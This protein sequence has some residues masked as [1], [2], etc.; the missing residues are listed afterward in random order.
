ML[1]A[2]VR[3]FDEIE[4][5]TELAR[6]VAAAADVEAAPTPIVD[7]P[8]AGTPRLP[9]VAKLDEE[10]SM[11]TESTLTED[12]DDASDMADEGALLLPA[13]LVCVILL[14]FIFLK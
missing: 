4:D 1:V 11:S 5:A 6:F 13:L 10:G 8:I 9:T 3:V 2:G 7:K 12:D 14:A